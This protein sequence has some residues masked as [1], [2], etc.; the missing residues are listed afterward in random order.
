M[1][2]SYTSFPGW[3]SEYLRRIVE[4]CESQ[5]NEEATVEDEAAIEE[6]TET[7]MQV[8]SELVPLVGALLADQTG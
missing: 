5:T 1:I 3:Y 7:F 8:H 2:D 6:A 4:H